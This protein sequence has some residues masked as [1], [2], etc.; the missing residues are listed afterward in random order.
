L[1]A[2]LDFKIP[3]FNFKIKIAEYNE[4]VRAQKNH[5][6]RMEVEKLE[7]LKA[8]LSDQAVKDKE[9]IEFRNKLLLKRKDQQMA[10]ILEKKA[11][12]ELKEERLKKFYDSVKPNVSADPTRV[13]SFTE[14]SLQHFQ[15]GLLKI[16]F[17]I[18]LNFK[19]R[20]KSKRS[21]HQQQQ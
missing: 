17:Y 3:L 13:I 8:N 19:V 16:H 10:S 14:V 21:R 15:L 20:V 2:G 6:E 12:L 1:H 11:E 7:K 5:V 18:C 4:R 9:R